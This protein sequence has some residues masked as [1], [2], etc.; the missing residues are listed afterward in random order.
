[1]ALAATLLCDP[2]AVRHT[3]QRH[4]VERFDHRH[5]F[6]YLRVIVTQAQMP[7]QQG[8]EAEHRR[9]RYRTPVVTHFLFPD[10][11]APAQML[12]RHRVVTLM[13]FGRP[14]PSGGELSVHAAMADSSSQ[15]V[16]E[17]RYLRALL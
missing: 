17:P 15:T 16:N 11:I 6:T 8:F 10:V 12:I 7:A 14:R 13:V 5:C 2:D 4:P 1:M 9:F 3:Q